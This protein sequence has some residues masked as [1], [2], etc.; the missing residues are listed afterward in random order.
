LPAQLRS[1]KPKF[2]NCTIW[3]EDPSA[4]E[5]IKAH[6]EQWSSFL[7]CHELCSTADMIPEK[8]TAERSD[9]H[10]VMLESSSSSALEHLGNCNHKMPLVVFIVSPTCKFIRNIEAS[11]LDYMCWPFNMMHVREIDSRLKDL[12]AMCEECPEFSDGYAFALK[13]LAATI[14]KHSIKEVIIPNV[15]GYKVYATHELLRFESDGNYTYAF[16]SN[17]EQVL[18]NK[19]L[20]HFEYVLD[21]AGFV[22]IQNAHMINLQYLKSWQSEKGVNL[23]LSDGSTFEVSFRWVPL[24]VQAFSK[25]SKKRSNQNPK[26]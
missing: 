17:G 13:F 4:G 12:Q 8:V 7:R 25:W 22:R 15:R 10:F 1:L 16:T 18:A 5:N 19:P 14:R 6:L 20:K 2:M 11:A 24:F 21:N 23:T 3:T 26:T 9:V